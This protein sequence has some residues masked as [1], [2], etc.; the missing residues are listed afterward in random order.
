MTTWTVPRQSTQ[1]VGPINVDHHGTEV[2]DWTVGVFPRHYQ[3]ASAAEISEEP[4]PAHGE[5][6]ILVGPN[7]DWPL[8]PGTYRIWVTFSQPPEVPVLNDVGLIKIV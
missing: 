7:S 4:T 3:P 1:W 6:G 5:L 8:L 2:T